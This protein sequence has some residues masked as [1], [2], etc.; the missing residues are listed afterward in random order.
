YTF[1]RVF[2]PETPGSAVFAEMAPQLLPAIESRTHVLILAYGRT[3]TGKSHTVN[4]IIAETGAWLFRQDNAVTSVDVSYTAVY[5]TGLY[6]LLDPISSPRDITPRGT[7][8]SGPIYIS[9]LSSSKTITSARALEQL[10]ASARTL[11]HTAA[12]HS[13]AESSRS[14]AILRLAF[15]SGGSVS[16]IDLAGHEQLK[17]SGAEG[18]AREEAT[19]INQSLMNLGSVFRELARAR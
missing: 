17:K 13:N 6:D 1:D 5:L 16:V 12:T 8:S 3:G 4:E 9:C 10:V 15:G 19:A 2:G 7:T 11:R 18:V 14:H